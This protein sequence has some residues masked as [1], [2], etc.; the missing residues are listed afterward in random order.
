MHDEGL[1]HELDPVSCVEL[2]AIVATAKNQQ[3]LRSVARLLDAPGD[4]ETP[5]VIRDQALLQ[6]MAATGLRASEIVALDTDD[7]EMWRMVSRGLSMPTVI[8]GG[9]PDGKPPAYLGC[10]V[11]A[12]ISED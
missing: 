11:S 9:S 4:K 8:E 6:L 5:T 10:K 1:G 2:G 3:L 12:P 7:V